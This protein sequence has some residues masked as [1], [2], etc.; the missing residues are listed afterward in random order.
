MVLAA[1]NSGSSPYS[2][3]PLTELN[4]Q[5]VPIR[6]NWRFLYIDKHLQA[7]LTPHY[8]VSWMPGGPQK[9]SGRSG[10]TKKNLYPAKNRTPNSPG[11][12]LRRT[13]ILEY[14]RSLTGFHCSVTC[15][16]TYAGQLAVCADVVTFAWRKLGRSVDS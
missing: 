3:Q 4:P 12:G 6:T 15:P 14:T 1:G 10:E 16:N 11:P 13:C 2:Q 8:T 5:S 9:R 7:D